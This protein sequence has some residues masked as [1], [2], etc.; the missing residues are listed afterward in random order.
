M[1]VARLVD[2]TFRVWPVKTGIQSV[3][4]SAACRWTLLYLKADKD[5]QQTEAQNCFRIRALGMSSCPRY[6][7]TAPRGGTITI[8]YGI[9]A[10]MTKNFDTTVRKLA[11]TS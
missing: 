6:L 1:A 5:L 10:S 8:V 3:A 4:L 7:A 2:T 11:G 9:H